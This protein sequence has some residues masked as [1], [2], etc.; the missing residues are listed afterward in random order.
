MLKKIMIGL[1]AAGLSASGLQAE[2]IATVAQLPK[3][4]DRR[5]V[6]DLSNSGIDSPDGLERLA[7]TSSHLTS[8][9]LSGN[10]LKNLSAGIGDF[11]HLEHLNL[12]GNQLVSLPAAIGKLTK[13]K[14]LKL[15][16]N[17]LSS[18]PR[19]LAMLSKL[20]VL[21]LSNNQFSGYVPDV[22]GNITTLEVLTLDNNELTTLGRRI[23]DRVISVDKKDAFVFGRLSNLQ[24]L[25][26]ANNRIELM[27]FQTWRRFQGA[28]Y[29]L[30][31]TLI[32]LQ[33]LNLKGN[34]FNEIEIRLINADLK[35][36][37][38]WGRRPSVVIE[39]SDQEPASGTDPRKARRH[40]KYAPR[41]RKPEEYLGG[42][43][44]PTAPQPTMKEFP[45]GS[46]PTAPSDS[47]RSEAQ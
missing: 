14:S 10:M 6:L 23:G 21:L 24:A 19:E 31:G 45:K 13:L 47:P 44:S 32:S 29:L 35:T 9:E 39:T 42:G 22:I 34:R 4:S 7:R 33:R 18:L 15:S 12:E 27:P 20:K 1:I 5:T 38:G 30:S 8:L 11:K 28:P 46:L 25:D 37:R 16:G 2:S 3:R 43:S 26:L 36:E 41:S 17:A 40:E